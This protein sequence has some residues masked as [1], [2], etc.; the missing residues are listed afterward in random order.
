MYTGSS[1]PRNK[2]SCPNVHPIRDGRQVI[3][4]QAPDSSKRT[5]V[6]DGLRAAHSEGWNK[7]GKVYVKRST[8]DF[9][10][11]RTVN[12]YGGDPFAA[13]IHS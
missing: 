8:A 13:R 2:A 1:V 11:R 4:A 9:K 6:T 7:L 3:A 12:A 10:G 5:T